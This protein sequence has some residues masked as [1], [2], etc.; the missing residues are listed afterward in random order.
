MNELLAELKK[1][2]ELASQFS[3]GYSERFFGAEEFAKALDIAVS[4]L[5][6][7]NNVVVED[8]YLWFLPTS[9]WD[10]F[11]KL[12]GLELGQRVSDL[13]AEYRANT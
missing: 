9:D 10:D 11:I 12:E 7:G 5:E 4:E 6:N 1:A 3:G 13:L 8:L 2:H